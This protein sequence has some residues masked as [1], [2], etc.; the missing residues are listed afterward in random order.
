MRRRTGAA[1]NSGGAM[2]V[3]AAMY[4]DTRGA[5]IWVHQ[6]GAGPAVLLLGGLGDPAESWQAQIDALSGRYRVV[7]P[8]NRG[9][10]RSALPPGGAS[11][12]A[13]AEDA[14]DVLRSLGVEDAHVAG[15]SMGGAVAQELALGHPSLVRSL[16]LS[17][18]WT[19]PHVYWRRMFASWV[20]AAE[21]ARSERELLESFFLWIYSREWH[22][23]GTVDRLI[24]E[25]LASPLAQSAEGFFAQARA[26]ADW[27][28]AAERLRNVTV[29]VLVIAGDAD[30]TC[31]PRLSRPILEAIPHAE[32]AVIEGG[33]HQPFQER[34]GEYNAIVGDFWARAD[35]RERI[36]A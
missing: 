10:G 21:T 19:V 33:A 4:I 9:A 35:G 31:P 29:P 28:G 25:T 12:A 5:R 1:G 22:E 13:M 14:A 17:G 16:V 11:V 32:L 18:T 15:F 7:A 23:D 27:T 20:A 2:S 8:D 26:C 34:P 24:D 36:A 6:Q 30:I 3:L